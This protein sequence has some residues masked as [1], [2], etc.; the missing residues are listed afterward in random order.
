MRRIVRH[1]APAVHADRGAHGCAKPL[2]RAVR[3]LRDERGL[4]LMELVMT[5]AILGIVVGGITGMLVSATRHE[6]ALNLGFQAQGS[7]RLA[8]SKLRGDLHCASSVAP[9]SGTVSSI[10]LTLAGCPTGTGSVTWCTVG[11]VP[12]YEL[13]RV[14]AA[15]CTTGTAGSRKWVP[16]PAA[17]GDRPWGLAAAGIFTP[18]WTSRTLPGVTVDFSVYSVAAAR[19]PP[20]RLVD[21]IYLRNGVRQ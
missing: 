9:T 6:V 14:P 21:T 4:V 3:R 13:W 2:P 10:R 8:L 20:Y 7:A 19:R 17:V 11:S 12:P 15:A 18:A 16:A 5:V 1:L